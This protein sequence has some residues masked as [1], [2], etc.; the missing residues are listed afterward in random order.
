MGYF[1]SHNNVLLKDFGEYAEKVTKSLCEHIENIAKINNRPYQFLY[2]NDIDKG[3]LARKILQ[4]NP[5][6]DGLIGIF[7][8][9]EVCSTMNVI[10]NGKT[11]K[12][13]LK[14]GPRKC[15]YYY[16]YYFDKD[17]GF[18][19]IKIQSWFPFMVQ[20]YINGHEWLKQQLIKENINFEMYNN[21][22]SYIENIPKAQEIADKI[23]DSKISD[24]FDSMIK[25]IN[26]FLPTIEE[27]FSHGYFWCLAECEYSTDIIHDSR[28][29]IDDYFKSLV[30][31]A[32]Y[33]FKCD[34]V[35]SFFGRKLKDTGF[36]FKGEITSDLRKRNQGFRL[37]H[38]MKS[39][40]IKM[41]DK[42]Y[43]IRI[44]TTINDPHEFKILKD[45]EKIVDHK[46]IVTEKKWLPMGKSIANLYRYAEVCKAINT[47]YI[48]ALPIPTEKE[49]VINKLENIS[50]RKEI[51]NRIY[52]G[53]NLF[54]KDD[55]RLFNI[56]ADAGLLI[57][58]FTNKILRSRYF[59]DEDDFNSKKIRNKTT[60][61]IDKLR[62]HG[63]IKKVGSASKYYVTEN[64]RK[65]INYFMLY[66]NKEI[67]EF[68]SKNN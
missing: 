67:P 49:I 46:E 38:K 51:N 31:N 59:K 12:L 60:R 15:K 28:E 62:K 8:N 27:T 61:L 40:Q 47:R 41:Y 4:E 23:I 3:E 2:G 43:S 16:L 55:I 14:W 54:N 50:N 65:I 29:S 25:E 7:S 53:F 26:N 6:Q 58:G 39:N 24:K 36:Q 11:K 64:G 66:Q 1:L 56:L 63:I 30:E 42:G 33:T 44:E 5:I 68:L 45:V 21:S 19:H 35:M 20:I 9:I 17:F 52:T 48:N 34:D 10:K 37:K 18:M 13:E 32:F 57:N 22:F